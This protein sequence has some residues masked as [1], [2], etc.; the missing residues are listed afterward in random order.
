MV[1]ER[2]QRGWGGR[3]E[4]KQNKTGSI[5]TYNVTLRHICATTVALEKQQ[6]LHILSVCL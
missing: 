5:H 6:A 2:E 3:E 4:R 1:R